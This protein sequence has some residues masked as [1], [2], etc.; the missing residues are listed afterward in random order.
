MANPIFDQIMKLISSLLTQN[1]STILENVETQAVAEV[2]KPAAPVTVA[3][4]DGIDWTDGAAKV[5]SHFTVHELLY[6]PTWKRLANEADGLD[7][8]IKANLTELAKAMDV[9]R[10]YFG[11]SINTHVTYRPL[12]YNKQIHGSLHSQHS[13]GLAMDFDVSGMT[14][15]DAIRQILKDDML[16]KWG[17]RC[18]NNGENPSWIHLDLK[19]LAPGGN[20]YF[21]P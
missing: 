16:E 4:T 19:P 8:T 5:S 18:E 14:C 20:R 13:V 1:R 6:L 9:V 2:A 12:E 3:I 17:M 21:K 15:G 11:K 10:D 7:A